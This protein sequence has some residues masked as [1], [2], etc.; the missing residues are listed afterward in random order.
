MPWSVGVWEQLRG[1]AG[2]GQPQRGWLVQWGR[3]RRLWGE[4]D[5]GGGGDTEDKHTSK[6]CSVICVYTHTVSQLK[7]CDINRTVAVTFN[8]L[9]FFHSQDDIL[10]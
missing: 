8:K 9:L 5:L 4:T 2:R 6:Y 1:E 10:V 7:S 3:Q